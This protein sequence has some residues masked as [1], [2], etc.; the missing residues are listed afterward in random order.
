M[1]LAAGIFVLL[2]RKGWIG[3]AD[4]KASLA[5]LFLDWT[6]LAWAWIG[7][8][9]Y[10]IGYRFIYRKAFVNPLP[11]FVGFT[12]GAIGYWFWRIWIG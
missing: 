10:S 11:G 2:W 9:V 4:L 7:A 12:I 6:L 5:L 8:A 3:G 1:S